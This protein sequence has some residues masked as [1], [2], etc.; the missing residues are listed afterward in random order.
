MGLRPQRFFFPYC[1]TCF[2]FYIDQACVYL[3]SLPKTVKVIRNIISLQRASVLSLVHAVTE[4][5]SGSVQFSYKM[6]LCKHHSVT[7]LQLQ[8]VRC[9]FARGYSS[10]PGQH[11]AIFLYDTNVGLKN[12][13]YFKQFSHSLFYKEVYVNKW[14]ICVLLDLVSKHLLYSASQK[15]Q[16]VNS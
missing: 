15:S 1:F 4:L 11:V 13:C 8:T 9:D 3:A 7:H 10:T 6:N 12:K 5:S 2:F 14:V 16:Q